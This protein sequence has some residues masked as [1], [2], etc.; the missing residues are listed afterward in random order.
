MII[1]HEE[2]APFYNKHI[3][4]HLI[5]LIEMNLNMSDLFNSEILYH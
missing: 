4:K 5:S 2:A 1:Y 3:D